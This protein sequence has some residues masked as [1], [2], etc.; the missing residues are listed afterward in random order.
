MY[1]HLTTHSAFSLQEGLLSPAELVQVAKSH[2][3]PAIGLTD[4]NLLTGVIEFV[5]ACK[6]ADIQSLIGLEI[7]LHDGPLSLLATSLDGWSD[8][9]R[10]SSAIALQEDPEAPCPLEVLAGHSRDLIGLSS[11]PER[12]KEIF[13]D[14]LYVNLQDPAEAGALSQMAYRLELPAVVTHPVYYRTPQQS[15]LQ[16]TLTAIRLNGN[17]TNLPR[18]SVA[19]PE[20]CFLSS[21]EMEIRFQ[22]YPAALAA[23]L[24]IAE[25]CRFDLPIGA[26]QMPTVPLPRG[27]DRRPAPAGESI[28]GSGPIVW[29]D[30]TGDPRC[31]WIMSW[32]SSPGWDLS[33][34]S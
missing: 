11:R 22:D 8:L 30:H 29:G 32:R 24:E 26:S 4:H 5:I 21:Q 13:G 19:P 6:A 34:S 27:I 1:I 2:G 33:R 10:L 23:T 17:I 12:L 7:H 14:R 25:R 18:Q 3:M 15:T 20:A 31:A 28:S 9:C 16:R